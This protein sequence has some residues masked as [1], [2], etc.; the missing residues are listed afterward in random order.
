MT[1][2][3]V[4]TDDRVSRNIG[5]MTVRSPSALSIGGSSS[6]AT[7]SSITKTDRHLMGINTLLLWKTESILLCTHKDPHNG[8]DGVRFFSCQPEDAE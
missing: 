4:D 5:C 1:N 2:R 7:R 6:A 3:T 8:E